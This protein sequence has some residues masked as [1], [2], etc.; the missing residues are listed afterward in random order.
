M[1]RRLLLTT[2]TVLWLWGAYALYSATV[3][4]QLQPP[5][6]AVRIDPRTFSED[7]GD[8]LTEADSAFARK[9][10]HDAPWIDPPANA[11][12][13]LQPYQIR[14]GSQL[15]IFSIKIESLP[16]GREL[17]FRPFAMLIASKEKSPTGEPAEP[18]A[19]IAEEAVIKFAN[20]IDLQSSPGRIVGGQFKG[21]VTLRGPD[22]LSLTGDTF[23]FEEQIQSQSSILYSDSLVKFTYGPH[24]GRGTQFNVEFTRLKGE[25]P[26]DLPAISGID[27]F[28][29]NRDVHLELVDTRKSA[30]QL[31]QGHARSR[32]GDMLLVDAQGRMTLDMRQN[33]LTLEDQVRL[34]HPDAR[35]K[36]DSVDCEL[37]VLDLINPDAGKQVAADPDDDRF[38]NWFPR[39]LELGS[40]TATGNPEKLVRINSPQYSLWGDMRS[41]QYDL[42]NRRAILLE[43]KRDG[44][45]IVQGPYDIRS[46]EIQ[47]HH[48]SDYELLT[49]DCLRPG[50]IDSRG[51]QRTPIHAEWQKSMSKH[52]SKEI[53]EQ[54][55]VELHG[56]AK[57]SPPLEKMSLAA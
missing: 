13:E 49:V 25:I 40:F 46:P 3:T 18:V 19:I 38:S 28:W 48:G 34:V 54:D 20:A 21:K 37:L 44:V 30:K 35:G 52:P 11:P 14:L 29:I 4:P 53:P 57:L 23:F 8:Q 7:F 43:E 27:K 1:F 10:L 24:S 50:R 42:R 51:D 36:Q 26:S 47:I 16:A 15:K 12:D 41:L 32:R 55:V 17:H 9:Y 56:Q 31:P 22:N 33:R 5:P 45:H 2:S 39:R 6:E